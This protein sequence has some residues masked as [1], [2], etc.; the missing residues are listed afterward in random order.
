M[1][2]DLDVRRRRAVY[3]AHHRGTKEMD[4]L[5]GRFA[6]AMVGEMA[7]V[8]LDRFER[9][10]ALPDPD[11]HRRI[12]GAQPTRD[13]NFADLIAALRSFHRLEGP[14]SLS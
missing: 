12:L 7:S 5:L 1:A 9:L 8:D 13:E 2:A 3:R 11:L 14:Y 4:W 10:L 6:D